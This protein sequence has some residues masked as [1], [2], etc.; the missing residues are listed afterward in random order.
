M[1]RDGEADAARLPA[2]LAARRVRRD[3]DAESLG[4]APP[5]FRA[6]CA[7]HGAATPT[8]P[9]RISM[10]PREMAT[11][12]PRYRLPA[13]SQS[14]PALSQSCASAA[15]DY[16][17]E[18][19]CP[20]PPFV[21][22]GIVA[23]GWREDGSVISPWLLSVL[24]CPV[25][26]EKSLATSGLTPLDDALVCASCGAAYPLHRDYVDMRPPTALAGKETVYLD[27]AADLDDP[28]IRP[29]VLSAGVRQRVLR[30]LLR[31]RADDALLE[32]GCGN[33]KFAVW[34]RDAVAH[35]VGLDPAARFA[36]AARAAV[37]L[38]QGDARALPFAPGA[39][40]GA[41]SVDVFEHLDL[42]GVRAHLA[43]VRRSLA[44][45]RSLFLLLEHAGA[46]VAQPTDRSGAAAVR[47]TASRR[48]RGP[49]ARSSPQGRPRQSGRND[50]CLAGR[51]LS[52]RPSRRSDSGILNPFI[53]TYV[54]TIAFAIVERLLDRRAGDRHATETVC[55]W[56]IVAVSAGGG[57]ATTGGACGAAGRNGAPDGRC[58]LLPAHPHRPVLPARAPHQTPMKV[59]YCALAIDITRSHGGATHVDRGR[60]R[61]WRARPRL[62]VIAA[63]GDDAHT[64][65]INGR[66]SLVQ[67]PPA[68][69]W[70]MTPRVRRI[71][72]TWRPD[73]VM[74]RFYT[75]AGGG[76]I[77]AHADGI[78]SL[79]EVNAPVVDPPGSRKE[80]ID[81]L[82]GRLMR[83]WATQQCRWA[84]R[85]VT[86]L[87]ATVPE[88]VRAKVDPLPWG[89]NISRFDPARL[90][91]DSHVVAG[92][93]ARYG[94][95]DGA[96]VIG[97]VG[98]FRPW[99]GAREALRCI[100]ASSGNRCPMRASSS[101]GTGRSVVHWS[102]RRAGERSAASSSPARA[103]MRTYPPISR[104]AASWSRPSRR[105]STRHCAI[106]ASTGRPSRSSRQWRWPCQ[107]SRRQSRRSPRSS[108][109]AGVCVPEGDS[110]GNGARNRRDHRGSSGT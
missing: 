15:G 90:P 97:F 3:H 64:G 10:R 39:F 22:N 93:R 61:A 86:P 14:A 23:F 103:A 63:G 50:R 4:R 82:T 65:Q 5:V 38:V 34:N 8:R 80:R 40:T 84:D 71:V 96:P 19:R 76:I 59:L 60:E 18:W 9:T 99:H 75:F 78:P 49:H 52:R 42:P 98:S 58:R 72:R 91:A 73:V 106:S 109:D 56:S 107:S 16:P 48:R 67:T 70:L 17:F 24:R 68:L 13:R 11:A 81:R 21:G 102:R 43:E 77:A 55:W 110:T 62:W 47:D 95:A 100:P 83:R 20:Y 36:E 32:I 45:R 29:P 53:A 7:G 35:M 79:L 92:L 57:G 41:Y 46:L 1:S 6:R 89:A 105:V 85:I 101:S 2:R 108:D 88:E 51:I 104:S 31:P 44:H 74:E 54:E 69:A 87:A 33:G 28:E 30:L 66:V 27:A 12:A 25:C 26:V 37:D 94:I